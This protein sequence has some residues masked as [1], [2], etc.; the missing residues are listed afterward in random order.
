MARYNVKKVVCSQCKYEF[1]VKG[2]AYEGT[3]S[4]YPNEGCDCWKK[5]KAQ[6]D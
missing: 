2:W 1:S 4:I 3:V 5:R 6:V